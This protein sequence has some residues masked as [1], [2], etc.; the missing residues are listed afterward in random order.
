MSQNIQK[1]AVQIVE[2]LGG[3]QPGRVACEFVDA[4]GCRHRLIDKAPIFSSEPLDTHSK[5]P[6][7]GFARCEIVRRWSDTCGR[8]LVHITT[9]RPDDIESAEGLSE[10][11][12]LSSQL[13]AEFAPAGG[14]QVLDP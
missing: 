10:F 2:F 14:Q 4:E 9:A 13:T 5:Y 12:V 6:Q 3:G 7:S 8:P 1:I 11:V